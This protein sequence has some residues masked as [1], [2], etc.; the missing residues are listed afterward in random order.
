[1]PPAGT[2]KRRRRAPRLTLPPKKR[3]K[4][5]DEYDKANESDDDWGWDD[6]RVPYHER[7]RP[8][9]L[10]DF[11]EWTRY[12]TFIVKDQKDDAVTFQT[13]GYGLIVH[14]TG[15]KRPKYLHEYW[16]GRIKEIR[17]RGNDPSAVWVKV[18]W[19]W[20]APE[21]AG[22]T[23]QIDT[24]PFGKME[25]LPSDE[26]DF[27]HSSC[28]QDV[29]HVVQFD[30]FSP[31]PPLI[32]DETFYF[33]SS[34]DF[35]KKSIKKPKVKT[36]CLCD[37]PYNPDDSSSMHFCPR[38]KCNKAFHTSCLRKCGHVQTSP[39][40]PQSHNR[41]KNNDEFRFQ[42]QTPP[43]TLMNSSHS[44]QRKQTGRNTDIPRFLQFE[45]TLPGSTLRDSQKAIPP[46]LLSLIPSS[47]ISPVNASVS[48]TP[49]VPKK[50]QDRLT[51]TR[52]KLIPA[53]LLALA[54][55]PMVRGDT[56]ETGLDDELGCVAGNVAFVTR[57][58]K[59]VER[60]VRG[61]EALEE[62]EQ[63]VKELGLP[64]HENG[65][66]GDNEGNVKDDKSRDGEKPKLE[67]EVMRWVVPDKG[68]LCPGCGGVI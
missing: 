40:L 36:T 16:V 41:G 50:K 65:R 56:L 57:A 47:P 13:S 52:Y 6:D 67:E 44:S 66:N 68:F 46:D 21:I 28:F 55:S 25:R 61:G 45:R 42:T 31:E 14:E 37:N 43:K 34:F 3:Q 26:W 4:R 64:L 20:S 54:R 63:W 35:N 32:T 33:R 2:K 30:E 48:Q 18:Q 27:V 23:K 59:I 12:K 8:S 29:A 15:G 19:L 5:T 9:C 51:F 53:A 11:S 24:K 38:K 58:R 60:V 7:G 39:L 22:V 1:M 62:E 49:P 10:A 17:S